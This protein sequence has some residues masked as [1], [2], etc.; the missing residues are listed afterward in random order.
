MAE[1]DEDIAKRLLGS[2]IFFLLLFG[3]VQNATFGCHA[4]AGPEA[5]FIELDPLDCSVH[6]WV[7]SSVSSMSLALS[8]FA[9]SSADAVSA[10]WTGSSS[11]VWATTGNWNASPVPSTGN[12]ATFNAASSNTSIN[13]GAGVL[14]TTLLF[15]TSSAVAYTLSTGAVGSQTLTLND[16]DTITA[17]STVSSSQLVNANVVL[18]LNATPALYS[19]TNNLLAV[20]SAITNSSIPARISLT[21]G[22]VSPSAALLG[23]SVRSCCCAVATIH[24]R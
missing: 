19:F 14:I 6:Q 8:L 16:S 13:L 1:V 21:C 12:T 24:E 23:R 10:T 20:P 4:V 7:H 22:P 9:I 2:K 3:L 15:D 17:N 11:G 18:E 5:D